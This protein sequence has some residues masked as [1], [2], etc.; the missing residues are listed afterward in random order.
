M[1]LVHVNLKI[2]LEELIR[3]IIHVHMGGSFAKRN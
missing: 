3:V 1:I 2:S